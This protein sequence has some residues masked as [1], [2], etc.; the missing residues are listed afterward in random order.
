MPGAQGRAGHCGEE[1]AYSETRDCRIQR[2]DRRLRFDP[3]HDVPICSPL[4]IGQKVASDSLRIENARAGCAGKA[5]RE[6]LDS[7][8]HMRDLALSHLDSN[9]EVDPRHH[10]LV[11]KLCQHG[12][13]AVRIRTAKEEVGFQDRS[14]NTLPNYVLLERC[15]PCTWANLPDCQI[16]RAHV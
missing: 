3:T 14:R 12:A 13:T 2:Y 11:R 1:H 16:G 9:S 5:G 6:H 8:D 4:L 10:I 7:A 15:H